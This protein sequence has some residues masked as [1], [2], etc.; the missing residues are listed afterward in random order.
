MCSVQDV[1]VL[2]TLDDP[3]AGRQR[4][5]AQVNGEELKD[6]DFGPIMSINQPLSD[7]WRISSVRVATA[8]PG[9]QLRRAVNR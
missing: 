7:S 5:D 9:R 4:H 3:F 8:K 6:E 1:P 2:G